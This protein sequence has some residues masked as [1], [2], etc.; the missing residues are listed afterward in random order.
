MT[1]YMFRCPNISV[2]QFIEDL[3]KSPKPV[4]AAIHGTALGGGLEVALA[5]HYR[6]GTSRCKV[7]FPEVLIGLLPGAGG[8][9]RLPRVCGPMVCCTVKTINCIHLS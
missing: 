4:V 7:G 5:C 3:G 2:T 9:Q 6:I 8:T 1:H